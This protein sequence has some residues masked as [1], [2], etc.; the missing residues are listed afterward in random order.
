MA[1]LLIDQIVQIGKIAIKN[2]EEHGQHLRSVLKM[3]KEEQMYAKFS[4]CDFWLQELKFLGH[5]VVANGIQVDSTKIETVKNWKTPKTQTQIQQFLGIAG[6]YRRFIEGF[7]TVALP[8]TALT[9]KSKKYEWSEPQETTFQLLK[10]KLITALILSLPEG[11][12]DI[13]IYC[14]ASRQ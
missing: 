10:E 1:S 11:N 12:K 13:V 2:I 7:S 4:K 5:V 14:D 8:L 6:Y 9:Q 3:L